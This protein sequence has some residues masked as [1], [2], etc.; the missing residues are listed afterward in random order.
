MMEILITVV[1]VEEDDEGHK[2]PVTR[3]FRGEFD[4]DLGMDYAV[5]LLNQ[6]IGANCLEWEQLTAQR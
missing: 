5:D 1:A 2:Y 6:N 3:V 4:A